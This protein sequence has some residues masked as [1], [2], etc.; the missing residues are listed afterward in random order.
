MLTCDFRSRHCL[1]QAWSTINDPNRTSRT[2]TFC[3]TELVNG[4]HLPKTGANII[5]VDPIPETI[6][7][8]FSVLFSLFVR[9]EG[10]SRQRDQLTLQD[11]HGFPGGTLALRQPHR[12]HYRVVASSGR[13]GR[14][15]IPLRLHVPVV[16]SSF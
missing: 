11:H 12:A 8:P 7:D 4:L 13:H 10:G 14:E 16:A 2:V 9:H 3:A 15:Q 1:L 6:N 5:F